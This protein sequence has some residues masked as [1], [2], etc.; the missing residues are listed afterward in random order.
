MQRIDD[1]GFGNIRVIQNKGLGYG[2]DAVLLA[3]FVAGETG[4][5]GI[6]AGARIADLGTDCGIVA[7]ILTHKVRGSVLTGIEKREEAARRASDAAVMNGLE[8]RVRII[9][10]D[11]IDIKEGPGYEQL[12]E[13]F[14]AVVSNPPYFRR[15]SA[16]PSSSEDRYTARHETTA[17]IGDFAGTAGCLLGRGGSFYLVHRPDR[18]ADIFTALRANNLEPKEMQLVVPSAGEAPNIV[19]IHSVMGAGPGLKLLPEIVVHSENGGYTEEILRIDE[20]QRK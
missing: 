12:H 19:L 15:N 1:T 7:F 18:L 2:V 9:N 13:S 6:R 10:A 8:D 17:D 5:R 14:D 20:R 3:A 11:I 4:A 16:I